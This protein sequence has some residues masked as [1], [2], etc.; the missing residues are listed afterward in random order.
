MNEPVSLPLTQK[1]SF[2]RALMVLPGAGIIALFAAMFIH[3]GIKYQSIPMGIIGGVFLSIFLI[4]LKSLRADLTLHDYGFACKGVFKNLEAKW[5]D[6]NQITPISFLGMNCT[7]GWYYAE[8]FKKNR[9]G[10][11]SRALSNECLPDGR[12]P[13][14][15]RGYST[16]ELADLMN[17]FRF[18]AT[19]ALP[20]SHEQKFALA[21]SAILTEMNGQRHDYLHGDLPSY[22]LAAQAKEVLSSSWGV[23]SGVELLECL[24]WLKKVGNRS[25]YENLVYA[26]SDIGELSDPLQL[27]KPEAVAGMN[28]EEKN[29]FKRQTSCVQK[30]FSLHKSILAWDLC[31]LVSV[32]RF[33][34]ASQYL[35]DDEAWEW[36]LDAASTQRNAFSSWRELADNYLIGRKFSWIDHGDTEVNLAVKKLL[37]KNN[38][39]SPWNHIPWNIT[40]KVY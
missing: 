23:S 7:I 15:Y 37:D 5:V 12:M 20:V 34:A 3:F 11:L 17:R 26:L 31:R 16:S 10:K 8:E 4:I 9:M 29:E 27:L 14:L 33:G 6:I 39:L 25:E 18:A 35:T 13:G 22:S 19:P 40:P 21:L 36:I 38:S 2:R 24:T 30:N 1:P 32:A 28:R